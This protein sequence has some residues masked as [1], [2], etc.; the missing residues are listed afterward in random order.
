M[1]LQ[2]DDAAVRQLTN[3]SMAAA[4]RKSLIA[5]TL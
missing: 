4:K 2:I 5:G 1:M 3:T